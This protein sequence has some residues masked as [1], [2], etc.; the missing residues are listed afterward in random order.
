MIWRLIK[1]FKSNIMFNASFDYDIDA[2][3]IYI[4]LMHKYVE[5]SLRVFPMFTILHPELW[6]KFILR[7][8]K[9][10]D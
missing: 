4:F 5:S 7:L 3:Y 8:S 10:S 1:D 6:V 9:V 2:N